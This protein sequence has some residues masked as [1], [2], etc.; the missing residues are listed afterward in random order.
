VSK[1]AKTLILKL[2]LAKGNDKLIGSLV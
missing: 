2:L 1:R